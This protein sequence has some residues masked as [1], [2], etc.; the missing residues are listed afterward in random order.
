[1]T[2]RDRLTTRA[3]R[4]HSR[5]AWTQYHNRL[6]QLPDKMGEKKRNKKVVKLTELL[7]NR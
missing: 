2:T 7:R 1:M 3:G 6:V 5:E 4:G